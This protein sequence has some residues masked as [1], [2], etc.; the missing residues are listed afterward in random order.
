MN[1]MLVLF[2]IFILL[3]CFFLSGLPSL[4]II[5]YIRIK[6]FKLIE[7]NLNTSLGS[8]TVCLKYCQVNGVDGFNEIREDGDEWKMTVLLA[9]YTFS[10]LRSVI[11]VELWW[12]IYKCRR[13]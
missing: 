3:K 8:F 11:N 12:A 7:L 9:Q 1:F 10:N 6:I 2:L 5:Y 13:V 4:K